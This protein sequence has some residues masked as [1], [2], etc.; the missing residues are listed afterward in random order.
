MD[1]FEARLAK[2]KTDSERLRRAVS[3]VVLGQDQVVEQVLWGLI[4]GGHVLLEGNPGLGKTLLVRALAASVDLK[5]SRIQFT[6]DLM[7]SDITGTNVLVLGAAAE[8][9]RRFEL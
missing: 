8:L 1:P 5:F 7:P 3:S 9:G 2:A 4:A 6:P